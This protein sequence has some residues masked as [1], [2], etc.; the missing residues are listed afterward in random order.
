MFSSCAETEQIQRVSFPKEVRSQKVRSCSDR[1][2]LKRKEKWD[3]VAAALPL[4]LAPQS[5]THQRYLHRPPWH[6]RTSARATRS[7]RRP[8]QVKMAS[9]AAQQPL[10]RPRR[11]RNR[12]KNCA[13]R[14]RSCVQCSAQCTRCSNT[15]SGASTNSSS[16]ANTFASLTK[17]TI[18]M[19]AT[20]RSEADGEPPPQRPPLRRRISRTPARRWAARIWWRRARHQPPA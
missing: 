7:H 14:C 8:P 2:P 5:A 3:A 6:R 13:K 10:R 4:L 15:C 9:A 17:M 19:T 1:I 12:S 20:K 11:R 16:Q 18:A